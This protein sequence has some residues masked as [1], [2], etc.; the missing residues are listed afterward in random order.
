MSFDSLRDPGPWGRLLLAAAVGLFS[1]LGSATPTEVEAF[2]GSRWSQLR[3]TLKRPTLV[4]FTATYC[5]TC[6]AA[7]QQ[8]QR[9]VQQ[10]R[11]PVDVLG[12]V[13]DRAPGE[14]DRTLLSTPYLRATQRLFAFDG[15][16]AALRYSVD[17]QWRGVT[18][19][20]VMLTPGAPPRSVV[21]PPSTRQLLQW[22]KP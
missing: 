1:P 10:H 12:V 2:D 15:T 17:P 4:V 21:G 5:P 9:T 6:P 3:E 14:D 8:V 16:P 19:Y 22:A 20:M 13:I 18:P 7:F 11:L